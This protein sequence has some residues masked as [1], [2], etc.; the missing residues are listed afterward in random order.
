MRSDLHSPMPRTEPPQRM[1]STRRGTK[2]IVRDDLGRGLASRRRQRRITVT[3][4]KIAAPSARRTSEV[5][6]PCRS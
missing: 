6:P 3:F 2:G 5:E 1:F 4:G